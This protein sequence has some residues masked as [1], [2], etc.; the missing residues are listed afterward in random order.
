MCFVDVFRSSIS[1]NYNNYQNHLVNPLANQEISAVG[2]EIC[3]FRRQGLDAAPANAEQE[4][5]AR[6]SV[7]C[8][9]CAFFCSWRCL[10]FAFFSS[11]PDFGK[12]LYELIWHLMA[13]RE[14]LRIL[15]QKHDVCHN[16][17]IKTNRF[18]MFWKSL[19]LRLGSPEKHP[20]PT[21]PPRL[22]LCDVRRKP[23]S[24]PRV[25]G[26][27][28]SERKCLCAMNREKKTKKNLR[29][30]EIK[31]KHKSKSWIEKS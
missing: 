31:W 26:A 25:S 30:L 27:C 2:E 15:K 8:V 20:L 1:I 17:G 14:N 13:S 3:T 6:E 23:G 21:L 24:L 19:V 10:F 12:Y 5:D 11:H 7:S 29:N 28:W 16:D 9:I 4:R 18:W 22:Q